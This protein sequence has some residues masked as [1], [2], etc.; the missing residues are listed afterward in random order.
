[1]TEDLLLIKINQAKN[2]QIVNQLNDVLINLR[3]T[4]TKNEIPQNRN[5][6]KVTNIAENIQ[7]TTNGSCT[8][9]R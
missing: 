4:V 5:P 2:E 8:S 7:Q 9:K 6:Y 1:M 3:K